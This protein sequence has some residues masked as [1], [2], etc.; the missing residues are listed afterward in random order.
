MNNLLEMARVGTMN[1]LE[2]IVWTN[3]PG[4]IPHIHIRDSNT[5]GNK[6]NCCVRLDKAEYFTHT[7]KENKL[8]S[9]QIKALIDFFNKETSTAGFKLTNWVKT[10]LYWNDNNS[11]IELDLSAEMPDYMLLKGK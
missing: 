11:N 5:H 10:L 7:G 8:N 4:N 2:I 1:S 3:D 6:F 9:K